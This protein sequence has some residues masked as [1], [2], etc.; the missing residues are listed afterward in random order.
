MRQNKMIM[1]SLVLLGALF[2]C[3]EYVITASFFNLRYNLL[4]GL[5]VYR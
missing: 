3:V 2:F 5:L 4:D 1:R